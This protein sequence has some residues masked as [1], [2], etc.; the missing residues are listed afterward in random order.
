MKRPSAIKNEG[1][2]PFKFLPCLRCGH[3]TVTALILQ[4]FEKLEL[5]DLACKRCDAPHFLIAKFEDGMWWA[6]Y[7]RD[8][9]DRAGRRGSWVRPAPIIPSSARGLRAAWAASG[10]RLCCGIPCGVVGAGDAGYLSENRSRR[11]NDGTTDAD[12]VGVFRG[13]TSQG[14]RRGDDYRQPQSAGVT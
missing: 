2:S 8:S 13:Q 12:A 1:E 14:C 7:D 11:I 4:P 9:R 6:V 3:F 10:R 5:L